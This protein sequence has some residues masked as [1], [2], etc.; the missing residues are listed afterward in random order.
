MSRAAALLLLAAGVLV[1]AD[2]DPAQKAGLQQVGGFVGTWNGAGDG[3][4]AGAKLLWRQST[5][6]AWKFAGPEPALALE[7]RRLR[8]A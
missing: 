6:W 4:P 3:K 7:H 5:T 8:G 2:P 1:A